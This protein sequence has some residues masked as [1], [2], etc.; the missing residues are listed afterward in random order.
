MTTT[1]LIRQLQK[2][3]AKHGAMPVRIIPPTYRSRRLRGDGHG[4][5]L[6]RRALA[7]GRP[8]QEVPQPL[9]REDGLAQGRGPQEW[10]PLSGGERLAGI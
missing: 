5:P 2:L 8:Q 1:Q 10:P 9:R 7:R 3:E 4:L 6:P